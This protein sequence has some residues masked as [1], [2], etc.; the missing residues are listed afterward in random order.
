M[1]TIQVWSVHNSMEFSVQWRTLF[2]GIVTLPI[3]TY[4]S[5]V[6]AEDDDWLSGDDNE[7]SQRND[8]EADD[9]DLEADPDEEAIDGRVSEPTDGLYLGEEYETQKMR[10]EGEDDADIYRAFKEELER[11]DPAEEAISWQ[12]YLEKYP[13]SIFRPAIE[14]RITELEAELYDERIEDRY[15]NDGGDGTAEIKLTQPIFLSNIDPRQKFH[16]GFEMGFPAQF[17]IMLDYEHQLKR[18]LSVHGGMRSSVSGTYFEPGVKYAFIKSARLQMLSTAN[19]DLMLGGNLGV[20]PTVG[21]GKRFTLKNDVLLDAMAQVGSE[22][23]FSPTFDPRLQGG[24]QIAVAPTDTIRFFAESSVYMKDFTWNRGDAFAFN[25]F[26]FGIKF[27]DQKNARNSKYEVGT[28]AN[29]PYYYKYWRQ[30]YGSI[31][32][33]INWYFE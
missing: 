2:F 29:I 6:F 12:E 14:Q 11:L 18:E 19:L 25:T 10:G 26:T 15:R 4:T 22:F 3:L 24:F 32:G 23:I 31:A 5:P 1:Q 20:R 13:K 8:G 16:A 21:W 33:D 7:D 27:F 17:N 28:A 30:H 9:I